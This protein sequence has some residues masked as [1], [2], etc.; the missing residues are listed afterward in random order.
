MLM[1]DPAMGLC[2]F[3]LVYLGVDEPNDACR[4]EENSQKLE[5][6]EKTRSKKSKVS[7]KTKTFKEKIPAC[8]LKRV[9]CVGR[10]CCG[11]DM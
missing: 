7:E 1:N 8:L 6:N 9:W 5:I 10:C 2:Y 3:C 11:V 4:C